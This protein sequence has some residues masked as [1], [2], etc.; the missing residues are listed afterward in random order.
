MGWEVIITKTAIHQIPINDIV[1]H[2]EDAE[3][4]CEPD[5]LAEDNL[6]PTYKHHAFD[7]RDIMEWF[8]IKLSLVVYEDF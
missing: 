1:N 6:L 4:L 5:V 3:C 8:D 7:A 2:V